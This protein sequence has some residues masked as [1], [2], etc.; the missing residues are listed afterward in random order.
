MTEIGTREN[1]WQL[2][3][4]PLTSEYTVYADTVNG[5]DLLVVG[6]AGDVDEDRRQRGGIEAEVQNRGGAHVSTVAA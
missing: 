5:Q 1:P 3:T 6:L 2:K 4:P